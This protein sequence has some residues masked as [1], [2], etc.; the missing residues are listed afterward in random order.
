VFEIIKALLESVS[1]L[2]DPVALSKLAKERRKEELGAKLFMLYAVIDDICIDGDQIVSDLGIY[3]ERMEK[4]AS[5]ER[6][7]WALGGLKCISG[8]SRHLE[9]QL[10]NIE[11]A[12]N[13]L[14]ELSTELHVID[15]VGYRRLVLLARGVWQGKTRA[16]EALDCACRLLEEGY[17]PLLGPTE[18]DLRSVAE[19]TLPK[20]K[21]SPKHSK[22][23]EPLPLSNQRKH[24]SSGWY[25]SGT[26]T[27]RA[28]YVLPDF[29]TSTS[30]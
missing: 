13:A 4:Y 25:D 29:G 24:S 27:I 16:L 12:R 3:V 22:R 8:I 17:V 19:R 2:I 5:V 7:R 26:S 6:D 11:K 20:T 14:E 10:R 1:K 30:S 28:R 15:P 9:Q 18:E 21:S 23:H